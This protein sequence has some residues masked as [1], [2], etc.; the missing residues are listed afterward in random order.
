M[1]DRGCSHHTLLLIYRYLIFYNG[2]SYVFMNIWLSS[3][4]SANAIFFAWMF[5]PRRR[6]L[7]RMGT[8][9]RWGS[10]T[11]GVAACSAWV[12]LHCS[13]PAS[14]ARAA[15]SVW[16]RSRFFFLFS[17]VALR[18]AAVLAGSFFPTVERGASSG[19][20][21]NTAATVAASF[22]LSFSR[23]RL[24]LSSLRVT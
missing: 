3:L 15:A 16:I 23:F 7:P 24:F 20:S 4:V 8:G 19:L 22:R 11:G 13:I 14:S 18:S 17:C 5:F 2:Q 12:L 1:Y 6:C 10:V 9:G 21:A